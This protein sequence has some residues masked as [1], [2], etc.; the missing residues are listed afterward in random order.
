MTTIISNIHE[1]IYKMFFTQL[2]KNFK[3]TVET[4]LFYHTHHVT[5]QYLSVCGTG[6]H[7]YGLVQENVTPVH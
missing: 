2:N 5:L 7:F 6:F 4:Y 1:I 3:N